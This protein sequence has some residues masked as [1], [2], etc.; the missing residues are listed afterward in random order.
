MNVFIVMD[1]VWIFKNL[2]YVFSSNVCSFLMICFLMCATLIKTSHDNLCVICG[3]Y[4]W[5]LSRSQNSEPI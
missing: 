1:S 2:S 3:F 5:F 4:C